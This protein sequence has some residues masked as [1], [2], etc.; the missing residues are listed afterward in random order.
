MENFDMSTEKPNMGYWKK[1]S[2]KGAPKPM[3]SKKL[4]ALI[5][6]AIDVW[7][8]HSKTTK[9]A[10][11]QFEQ[12]MLFQFDLTVTKSFKIV[13]NKNGKT[14]KVIK[15]KSLSGAEMLKQANASASYKPKQAIPTSLTKE[16]KK[17]I[18]AGKMEALT[19][20]HNSRKHSIEFHKCLACKATK[21][22]LEW[23]YH[24]LPLKKAA[25]QITVPK[26]GMITAKDLKITG[27]TISGKDMKAENIGFKNV[28]FEAPEDDMII[29][30]VG[31][32]FGETPSGAVIDNFEKLDAEIKDMTKKHTKS[33]YFG[34]WG[35]AYFEPINEAHK[36]FCICTECKQGYAKSIEAQQKIVSEH[37]WWD[38]EDEKILDE[39]GFDPWKASDEG[40]YDGL[41]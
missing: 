21:A 14:A 26:M 5:D 16:T 22:Y 37:G 8:K 12:M 40:E 35:A 1:K 9:M 27:G 30:G 3:T 4:K 11:P 15:K 29:G 34:T 10:L 2:S 36:P 38:K 25:K 19:Y 32:T 7:C 20:F 17:I 23:E 24:Y 13:L 18:M 33:P 6:V 31:V 28:I 41:V 39:D